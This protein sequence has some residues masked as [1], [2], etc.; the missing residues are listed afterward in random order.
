[1][2]SAMKPKTTMILRFTQVAIGSDPIQPSKERLQGFRQKDCS[3]CL[4]TTL[5]QGK[6]HT[7]YGT[8][9]GIDLRGLINIEASTESHNRMYKFWLRWSLAMANV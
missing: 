3:I 6:D 4:L 5:Q 7:R 8:S 9:S 2:L 1:M